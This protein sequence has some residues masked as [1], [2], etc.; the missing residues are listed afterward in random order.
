M[1]PKDAGKNPTQEAGKKTPEDPAAKKKTEE[2][3]AQ[4]KSET[5]AAAKKSEAKRQDDV[6]KHLTQP[7]F[8]LTQA[9]CN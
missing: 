2:E 9:E 6:I 4:K 8:M 7:L 3:Q 5:D 1:K